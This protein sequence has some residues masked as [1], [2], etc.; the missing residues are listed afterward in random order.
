MSE[1]EDHEHTPTTQDIRDRA[2]RGT[3]NTFAKIDAMFGFDSEKVASAEFDRWL[4]AH[5]AEVRTG[6]KGKES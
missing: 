3:V 4:D 1:T 2:I 5:D 6:S